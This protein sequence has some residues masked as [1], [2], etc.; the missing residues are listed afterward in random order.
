MRITVSLLKQLYCVVGVLL[1]VKYN[2]LIS[3]WGSV[4]VFLWFSVR[5]L[6][7]AFLCRR[8]CCC[9]CSFWVCC[10]CSCW[11]FCFKSTPVI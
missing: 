4:K 2:L 11:A 8:F 6:A 9:F 3:E 1:Y 10:C 7:F 5:Q